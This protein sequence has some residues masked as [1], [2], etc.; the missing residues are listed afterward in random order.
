MK[1][2]DID[3]L[4]AEQLYGEAAEN[5]AVTAHL[6]KCPRCREAWRDMRQAHTGLERLEADS[7]Q[8]PPASFNTVQLLQTVA[9]RGDRRRRQ[10]RTVAVFA[11]VSACLAF[12]F[13]IG[14]RCEIHTGHLVIRWHDPPVVEPRPPQP[15]PPRPVIPTQALDRL[16]E[17]IAE[18]SRQLAKLEGLTNLAAREVLE[19]DDRR[20]QSLRQLRE[21]WKTE[22]AALQKT[23]DDRWR[24]ILNY[25]EQATSPVVEIT[26]GAE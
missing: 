22:L 10:W 23:Q 16:T 20:E 18:Q 6:S 1:C 9:A 15:Q 4:L 5:L 17:Q 13:A 2:N 12:A 21:Q 11:G 14:L 26:T 19:T 25:I 7:P 3:R 8:P 24:L